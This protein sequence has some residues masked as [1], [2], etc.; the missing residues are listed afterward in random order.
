MRCNYLIFSLL[1]ILGEIKKKLNLSSGF[2]VFLRLINVA[3]EFD[4][5]DY[6]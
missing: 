6:C 4:K 1:C 5:I 3:K 2:F